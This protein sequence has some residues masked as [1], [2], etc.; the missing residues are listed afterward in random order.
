L[1][2]HYSIMKQEVQIMLVVCI[3]TDAVLL[4]PLGKC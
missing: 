1:S 4:L 3:W 2:V